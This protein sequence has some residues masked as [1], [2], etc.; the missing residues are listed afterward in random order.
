[1]VRIFSTK[2]TGRVIV[3]RL[4]PGEDILKSIETIVQKQSIASG[5]LSLIGAVSQI[6]LGYFDRETNVYCDFN[7]KEDLEVVSCVGNISKHEGNHVVHAHLVAADET[8]KCYGGHLMEGCT[9]SVTIEVVITEF[10]E[11]T[12]IRDNATGLN[13]LDI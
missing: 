2:T 1:M 6:H 3:A 8:G 13:L 12:R 11:M 5:H 9:V 10:T 4:E 7:V